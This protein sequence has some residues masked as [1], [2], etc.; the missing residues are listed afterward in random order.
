MDIGNNLKVWR[1]KADITQEQL[2][3]ELGLS[4]QTINSVERGKF[5]PSVLSALKI[6]AFFK[7]SVEEVFYLDLD[8][9]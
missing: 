6:A 1:A 8:K 5:I 7:T 4:R 9:G 3:N 2:A